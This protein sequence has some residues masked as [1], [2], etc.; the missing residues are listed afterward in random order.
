VKYLQE[1]NSR[2]VLTRERIRGEM[3]DFREELIGDDAKRKLFDQLEDSWKG[4]RV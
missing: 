1:S 4:L 3:Q 2:L